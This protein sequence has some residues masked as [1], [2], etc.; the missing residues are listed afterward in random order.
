MKEEM[1]FDL[2]S[3]KK[4]Y[5]KLKGASLEV[6]IAEFL[7]RNKEFR[8]DCDEARKYPPSALWLGEKLKK[9]GVLVQSWQLESPGALPEV[10]IEILPPVRGVRIEKS[11]AGNS[12]LINH[13]NRLDKVSPSEAGY[14][15]GIA[16]QDASAHDLLN[17]LL[18]YQLPTF[19]SLTDPAAQQHVSTPWAEDILLLAVDLRRPREEIDEWVNKFVSF[20][21]IKGKPHALPKRWIEYMMIYDLVEI[22]GM[23]TDQTG[24]IM[25]KIFPERKQKKGDPFYENFLNVSKSLETGRKL[26]NGRY[27]KYIRYFHL[28]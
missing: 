11:G 2:A 27:K 15:I 12:Q 8:E 5:E 24:D 19:Q 20:H 7:R 4:N 1:P 3:F 23:S 22:H 26:I 9:Y 28:K 10:E 13:L 6:W 18:D 14:L 25:T 21:H 17:H 16:N